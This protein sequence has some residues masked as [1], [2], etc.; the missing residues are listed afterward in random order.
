MAFPVQ[1]K[2]GAQP[3]LFDFAEKPEVLATREP[4]RAVTEELFAAGLEEV[5]GRGGC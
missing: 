5:I 1:L 2:Y 4:R 3:I